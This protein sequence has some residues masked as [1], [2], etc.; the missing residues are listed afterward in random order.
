M[1]A[2]FQSNYDMFDSMSDRTATDSPTNIRKLS[3]VII[4]NPIVTINGSFQI[5]SLELITKAL[6]GYHNDIANAIIFKKWSSRGY[7]EL[8]QDSA[9]KKIYRFDHINNRWINFGWAIAAAQDIYVFIHELNELRSTFSE[10]LYRFDSLIAKLCTESFLESVYRCIKRIV[11]KV[12]ICEPYH[13]ESCMDISSAGHPSKFNIH[14]GF[15][16][17][18]VDVGLNSNMDPRLQR[19]LGHIYEV[20][21]NSDVT[22]Y[23]Y[24]LSWLAHPLRTLTRTNVALLLI[25]D[26][27][28]GKTIIFRFMKEYVY[29]PWMSEI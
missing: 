23:W 3:L 9:T 1:L 16:A 8:I 27:G 14:P 13:R 29:G 22:T 20:W 4:P 26:I 21:A 15:I 2:S 7:L 24:L 18:R 25:G 6:S 5:R 19:L 17:N 28:V 11:T 10:D 12:T